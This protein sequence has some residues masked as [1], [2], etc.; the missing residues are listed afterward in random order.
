[1]NTTDEHANDLCCPHCGYP[2][3]VRT[4]I[5]GKFGLTLKKGALCVACGRRF[6]VKRDVFKKLRLPVVGDQH[7]TEDDLDYYMR[8]LPMNRAEVILCIT[9]ILLGFIV[10]F[11]LADRGRAY[12]A[13][14]ALVFPALVYGAWWLGHRISPPQRIISGVCS[15]CL[16]NL[17]GVAGDR[18]PECGEP[19]E[20]E[21]AEHRDGE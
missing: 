18:C 20:S 7:L 15:N 10:W 9:A 12:E 5:H 13:L 11:W 3:L 1:M 21:S 16:Y 19:I 14:G 2:D 4:Q 17:R 6:R 8:N